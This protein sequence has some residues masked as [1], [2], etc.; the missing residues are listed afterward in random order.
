MTE[1]ISPAK[2]MEDL[3]EIAATDPSRASAILKAII[4]SGQG[5]C[6]WSFNQ[7]LFLVAQYRDTRI[8]DFA[9]NVLL[10]AILPSHRSFPHR[11]IAPWKDVKTFLEDQQNPDLK[12][13]AMWAALELYVEKLS[14][15]SLVVDYMASD[16][17]GIKSAARKR[18]LESYSG[19]TF[20]NLLNWGSS[21]SRSV[22]AMIIELSGMVPLKIIDRDD[23]ETRRNRSD[24]SFVRRL[25]SSFLERIRKQEHVD[26]F[27]ADHHFT[28]QN[29]PTKP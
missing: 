24:S 18:L 22:H 2:V 17:E 20:V 13:L 1:N 4:E 27:M 29:S 3:F 26:A 14:S 11:G 6:A 23:V 19:I 9:F 15:R 10:R 21:D 7:L 16:R 5:E 28:K 8:T 25:A 12:D